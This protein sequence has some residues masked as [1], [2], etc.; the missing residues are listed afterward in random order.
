MKFHEQQYLKKFSAFF[1][2]SSKFCDFM[3]KEHCTLI[4]YCAFSLSN[5]LYA[6]SHRKHAF[7]YLNDMLFKYIFHFF[8]FDENFLYCSNEVVSPKCISYANEYC[9]LPE[10]EI[11]YPEDEKTKR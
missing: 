8:S 1:W 7:V 10:N 11:S 5:I 4:E 6:I 2:D 9:D 3:W